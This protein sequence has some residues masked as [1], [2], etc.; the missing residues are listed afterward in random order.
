MA[1]EFHRAIRVASALMLSYGVAESNR[2]PDTY[3]EFMM[4][5]RATVRHEPAARHR[6][7]GRPVR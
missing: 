3:A 4:R 6:A 1:S 7:D 2:P 5:S